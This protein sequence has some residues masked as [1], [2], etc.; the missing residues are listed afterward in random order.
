RADRRGPQGEG[1]EGDLCAGRRHADDVRQRTE[2]GQGPA[3]RVRGEA[4]VRVYCHHVQA[5][6]ALNGSCLAWPTGRL[7][8]PRPAEWT[9]R[10]G[11]EVYRPLPH[12]PCPPS[13]DR[14]SPIAQSPMT[15]W[16]SQVDACP[17][18]GGA[19]WQ[20]GGEP[21]GRCGEPLM[22][23]GSPHQVLLLLIVTTPW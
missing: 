12:T 17:H 16:L 9:G 6:E 20:G 13:S 8:V 23:G 3:R 4:G 2:P 10:G 18:R 5:R 1:V 11:Q 21:M 7:S 19:G 14:P 22:S 15:S